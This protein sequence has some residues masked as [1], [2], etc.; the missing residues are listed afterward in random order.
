MSLSYQ[1]NIRILLFSLLILLFGGGIAIWQ[2]RLAVDREINA[3][4]NLTAHLLGCGLAQ[5]THH[6]AAWL[7]CINSLQETRHLTIDLV[8]PSGESL[9][10]V[11]A[12]KVINNDNLPPSWF[13]KLIGGQRAKTERQI[14]TSLGEQYSLRIQAN[15]LD[16]IK[17]AWSESLAFFG[18][19]V[20]LTQ[21]AFLS[22]YTALRH[23]FS[24]IRT[25]VAALKQVETG[26]YQ[27]TLPDLATSEIN[28]IANAINHMTSELKRTQR[29]NHALVQHSL[30]LL[31][32]ERKQIAQELHDEL[33]Q[34]LTA[35]K[36]MAITQTR[37]N[38]GDKEIAYSIAGICDDLINVVRSIMTQLHPLT[39]T[40]LGLKAAIEDLTSRWSAKMPGL[41]FAFH[42]TG[43][44]DAID[45]NISIQVFRVIQECLTNIIRHAGA[46]ECTINLIIEHNPINQICLTVKDDGKGSPME[47]LNKGFG[48]LGMRERIHSLGGSLS[49][50]SS[51]NQGVE[52][53]ALIPLINY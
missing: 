36:M 16:E 1:I 50:H 23:T 8:K 46:K 32:N 40:E 52:V 17:E 39:L 6:H 30:Q 21:L 14:T 34:S 37:K 35:I 51:L 45:P 38:T 31:E 2:A 7:D 27:Q 48:V 13:V 4:I 25:I 47:Q 19:V 18:T 9:G 28:K 49:M 15:P 11:Q 42:C 44:V 43:A 22:V 26:D 3:S 20:A 29:E 12:K 33:G 10:M 24:S 5:E 53:K 41:K